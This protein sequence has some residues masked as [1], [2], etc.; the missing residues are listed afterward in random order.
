MVA[1][2]AERRSRWTQ[3]VDWS[4][5]GVVALL[6]PTGMTAMLAL[7]LSCRVAYGCAE[8]VV[9]LAVVW[10]TATIIVLLLAAATFWQA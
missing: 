3:R 9:L 7:R 5:G 6:V 8:G 4:T 1:P 10:D 2:L